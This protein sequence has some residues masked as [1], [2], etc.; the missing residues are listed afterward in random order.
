ME[1]QMKSLTNNPNVFDTRTFELS[2]VIKQGREGAKGRDP[3]FV[4][5]AAMDELAEE[6]ESVK[7][8]RDAALA[9]IEQVRAAWEKGLETDL[10]DWPGLDPVLS[11]SDTETLEAVKADVWD[12]GFT[13]G[14]RHDGRRDANPYRKTGEQSNG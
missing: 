10:L 5:R 7:A 8:E 3:L 4:A 9:V 6:L 14:N 1:A 11:T 12:E 13:I 2:E